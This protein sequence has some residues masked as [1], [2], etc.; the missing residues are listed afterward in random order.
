VTA[1]TAAVA[2]GGP[3]LEIE[4]L[5]LDD[6]RP[7]EVLVRIAAT[8]VCHT[9]AIARDQWF[10]VPMPVVLGHEGAGV[11]E[12][13]GPG[14]RRVATGDRVV[15]SFDSCGGC[16]P[17]A[18]ARP[19]YCVEAFERSFG[20]ERRD[21]SVALRR[22]QEAVH[23]HFFGQSSFATHSLAM[24]RSVVKVETDVPIEALG[25][26]GCGVQTGAGAV[27]NALRCEQGSTLVVFGTGAVGLSAVMAANVASC[28]RVI[29][30]DLNA[31]RREEA[32]R[33]GATHAIDP[34]DGDVVAAVIDAS[35]GGVDYAIDTTGNPEV[36]RAAIETL[37]PLGVCGIVG[38]PRV[39]AELRVRMHDLFFG[40]TVRGIIEGD[41]VPERFIPEMIR[42][43]E[44][45]HFPFDQLIEFYE[46]AEI[47]RA[48]SDSES[49][50]V[51]KPV[52]R[53]P[54]DAG[55][56]P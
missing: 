17:C 10:P 7:G 11:V 49:G 56:T 30:V 35:D 52:I 40:R 13:V 54:Q 34:N 24:E 43:H 42:L 23:S 25:P 14:V 39:D 1:V 31:S 19:S 33:L 18:Q 4:A 5:E 51:V 29:A 38:S 2:R 6:P 20:G 3:T 8:G 44:A 27:L 21:G 16:G 22:G 55:G 12:A 53:M 15:L 37:G 26:L 36:V 46:L 47:N 28:T 50:L 45:G 9:D 48:L 32:L 41:S